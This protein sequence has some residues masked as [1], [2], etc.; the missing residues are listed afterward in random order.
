VIATVG[1]DGAPDVAPKGS[2]MVWDADHL[3]FWERSHGTTIANLRQ[4]HQ[5]AVFSFNRAK[6]TGVLRFF[7]RAELVED[8]E[9]RQS[10]MDRVIE[11]ELS[12]DPERKGIA[13]LIRVDK[14]MKGGTLI[15]ARSTAAV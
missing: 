3:A 10:I 7:G 8:A 12:K 9:L 14:V 5:V 2:T 4:N 11:A 15:Q 1:P 13:V 6:G